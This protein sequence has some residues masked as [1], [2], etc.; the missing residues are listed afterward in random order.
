MSPEMALN[1]HALALLRCLFLRVKR[2]SLTPAGT[3]AGGTVG[4]FLGSI[5]SKINDGRPRL[6]VSAVL[7]YMGNRAL[8][9][10]VRSDDSNAS[11]ARMGGQKKRA[12]HGPPPRRAVSVCSSRQPPWRC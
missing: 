8:R 5:K 1:G 3:G 12:A 4:G 9:R 2:I 11:R 7:R 10:D 6:S